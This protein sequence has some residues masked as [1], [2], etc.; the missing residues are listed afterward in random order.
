VHNLA[1]FYSYGLVKTM[2][3]SAKTCN[4]WRFKYLKYTLHNIRGVLQIM[5]SDPVPDLVPNSV[6]LHQDQNYSSRRQGI[7]SHLPER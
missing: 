5:V 2:L 7:I 4:I 1:D 3:C 6:I